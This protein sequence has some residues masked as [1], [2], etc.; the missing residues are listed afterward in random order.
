MNPGT[1]VD[2]LHGATIGIE[3]PT[4]TDG[5]QVVHNADY[6][7]DNLAISL[8]LVRWLWV[9]PDGGTVEPF[10][11]ATV[12]V[13]FNAT[14]LEDGQYTGQLTITSNDPLNG[15]STVPVTLSVSSW[16]CGDVNGNGNV[17][18][19]ADLTY[20]VNFLFKAGPQPPILAAADCNGQGG[21]TINVSDL[22]YLVSYLFK[23]GPAPIC[24]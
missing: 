14:D 21:N 6:M 13:H 1:D 5:L 16:I 10:S 22:T 7:H 15:S 18:N 24:H 4:G 20:L 8:N 3:N 11:S 9:E 12:Q 19:V 2:G 17:A 23:S